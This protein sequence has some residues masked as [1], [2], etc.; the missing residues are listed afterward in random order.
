MS[1]IVPAAVERLDPHLQM[2]LSIVQQAR[3]EDLERVRGAYARIKVKAEVA[4]FLHRSARADRR[5]PPCRLTLGRFDR[6]GTGG[7]R[8]ALDPGAA[9]A[10]ARSGPDGQ[11]RRAGEQPAAR[12]GSSRTS[13]RPTRLAAEI[14]ELAGAPRKLV[15]MAAAARSQGATDA[16][17]RLAD[18][19]L[20][21][22]GR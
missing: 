9:A 12:C 15:A 5:E 11:C 1:D 6:G 21:V 10:C 13:S 19:V 22:A 3:G 14:S 17:E 18:L 16:A 8:P 4:D 7:D 20:K 2:R